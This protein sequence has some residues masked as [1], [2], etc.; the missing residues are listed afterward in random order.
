[1]V[2]SYIKSI[3]FKNSN[4]RVSVAR[5]GNVIGGGDWSEERLIPDCMRSWSKNKPVNIRSSNS[6]RPWQHVLEVIWGYITLAKKLNNNKK[7]HGEAFNFGPKIKL[8]LTVL[9]LLG[10]MKI[11][12]KNVSW[13]ISKKKSFKESKL[14][15][16]NSK[17]A[18][19]Y[20]NWE[21][22]LNL[23]QTISFLLD[24]YKNY[25]FGNKNVRE[26]STQQIK[27]YLK[28]LRKN[29]K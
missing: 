23:Q 13:K 15:K 26:F 20:L 2:N 4:L 10:L 1:L 17:K 18:K 27:L 25:Y 12:W 6:T 7:L 28:I 29:K 9:K 19:K 11:I 3:F 22:S 5:A 8:R 14:L 16:L 21:C 24:W